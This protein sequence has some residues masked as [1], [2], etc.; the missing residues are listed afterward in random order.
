MR[1]VPRFL[2][3]GNGRLAQ[4]FRHYF[5]LLDLSFVTW[6]RQEPLE[7]LQEKQQD[8]SH[9]LLLIKDDAIENFI[10]DHLNSTHKMLIHC[11]GS[12]VTPLAYGVH[13]LMTFGKE[14][15]ALPDYQH[16]PFIMD[17]DAPDFHTLFPGLPNP[18][19]RL[20][21]SLKAKYHALCVLSCNFSSLLWQ[22]LLSS[23]EHE[24]N[25]PSEF[26]FPMLQQQTKNLLHDAPSALTGPLVRNDV[27][28]IEKN[29]QALENDVFQKVYA[30][31]VD[32][33]K[34]QNGVVI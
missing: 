22:K 17:H 24:F 33:Y 4:H 26:V 12:L 6:T 1:Q 30:S 29:L 9:I 34:N 19:A 21:K 16:I 15:Y 7:K 8:S 23:L 31:F 5:S 11:S 3:I 28:T 32:S 13:P 10:R 18:H 14:L 27:R 20:H 2:I 25:L